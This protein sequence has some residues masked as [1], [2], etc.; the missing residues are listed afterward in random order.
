MTARVCDFDGCGRPHQAKGYCSAHR[1]QLQRGV[2]LGPVKTSRPAGSTLVRD[3]EGNKLCVHCFQWKPESEYHA[4]T[5][6]ALDGL[7][8]WCKSCTLAYGR[9]HASWVVMKRQFGIT[10]EQYEG[11]VARQGGR[12]AIEACGTEKPG[13]K[14]RWHVD[15]D[16]ACCPGRTSCGKCVRGLLC[17]RCNL[18]LGYFQDDK[19]FLLSAAAYLEDHQ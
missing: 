14:G 9:E 8:V 17:A 16:H 3:A 6:R 13:G 4:G 10:K 5:N 15:H 18:G 7:K 11:I 12:C 19:E 2:P 1:Q